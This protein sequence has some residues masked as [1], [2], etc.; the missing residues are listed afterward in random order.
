[1]FRIR[2]EPDTAAR[3]PAE[4]AGEASETAEK[5]AG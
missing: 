2:S 1:M 4:P 5:A 3:E